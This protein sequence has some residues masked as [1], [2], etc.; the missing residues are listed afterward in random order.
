[1]SIFLYLQ[2]EIF[3][4]IFKYMEIKE[5]IEKRKVC[6]KINLL[7]TNYIERKYDL[8]LSYI[9]WR[10]NFIVKKPDKIF[11]NKY[12]SKFLLLIEYNINICLKDK[13]LKIDEY[14]LF[15]DNLIEILNIM[16]NNNYFS[17]NIVE[18]CIE[19]PLYKI[20]IFLQKI[21]IEEI[22]VFNG[23]VQI[24][25]QY[26]AEI[27]LFVNILYKNIIEKTETFEEYIKNIDI[28][29]ILY[30][31]VLI[32]KDYAFSN[33]IIQLYK[34]IKNNEEYKYIK[35]YVESL[36][37]IILY[38][39]IEDIKKNINNY[40]NIINSIMMMKSKIDIVDRF[41]LYNIKIYLND[42]NNV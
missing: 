13:T 42:F 29:L 17:Q 15:I 23:D 20:E 7:I 22:I 4:E 34:N 32:E 14:D 31:N 19:L 9:F 12:I 30:R 18:T 16:H 27:Q 41:K 8:S 33:V 25:S 11:K 28:L 39:D 26:N 35:I 36:I 38:L 3:Y 2:N 1:M 5:L 24:Y 40:I 21:R 6:K 10:N 37:Y